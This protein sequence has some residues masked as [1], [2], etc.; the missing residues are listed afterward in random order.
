MTGSKITSQALYRSTTQAWA[1][2]CRCWNWSNCLR[3]RQ[4]QKSHSFGLGVVLVTLTHQ[5]ATLSW[6]CVNLIGSPSTTPSVC[7]SVFAVDSNQKKA[8]S[9]RY[10]RYDR[11]PPPPPTP[12]RFVANFLSLFPALLL[13]TYNLGSGVGISV[14]QLLQ[15]FGQVTS[16][17]VAYELKPRREGDICAMYSNGERAKQELGWTPRFSLEQMCK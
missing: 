5:S 15:T 13:Q 12:T 2:V 3:K 17:K 1:K 10:V 16:T 14:L 7:V 4:A 8:A 9:V 6:Q 11:E